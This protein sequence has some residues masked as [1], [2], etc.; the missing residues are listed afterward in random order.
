MSSEVNDTDGN[1]V[2]TSAM[3]F[4]DASANIDLNMNVIGDAIEY[5]LV[6]KNTSDEDYYFDENSLVNNTDY[7]EYTVSYDDNDNVVK[8]GEEK[9]VYLKVT[10]KNK[11]QS[12]NN[13]AVIDDSVVKV[14]LTNGDNSLIIPDTLKDKNILIF[15]VLMI[16]IGA[17]LVVIARNR[18]DMNIFIL[19]ILPVVLLPFTV[20]AVCKCE[21]TVN[22]KV[23][24]DPK[25]A[26]FL[27]GEEINVKIKTLAGIDLTGV[28]NPYTKAATNITAIKKATSEPISANKEEKNIVSTSDSP[29][30]IY[31]WFDNGTLY[32]WSEDDTPA[33][34]KNSQRFFS[35]LT[36]M[37]DISGIETFDASNAE[38]V[39]S[40]LYYVN[41]EDI[42]PLRNWN[43][44]S[45]TQT[46]SFFAGNNALKRTDALA[47][48]DVSNVVNF[49]QM[50]L[51]NTSLE[52]LEGLTNWNTS[53][54]KYMS[55]LFGTNTSLKSIK[56]LENW[57]VSHFESMNG[58]LS[59]CSNLES[60][61]EIENWDVSSAEA[62]YGFFYNL[63]KI[64]SLD[65][66]KWNPVNVT[67]T[68]SM[69]Y[70]CKELEELDLSSW[71][72]TSKLTNME[73]MFRGMTKLK[74][75]NISKFDTRA[76]TNFNNIFNDSTSLEH[77]Y[78]GP[79]WN[80]SANTASTSTAFP[81]SCRLPNFSN[82]N[83]SYRDLRWANTSETGYLT[84]RDN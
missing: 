21:L 74:T 20:N 41:V 35:R 56:G 80:I 76:V 15:V 43:T 77:I 79:N 61:K 40:F 1:I 16:I 46:A 69:F 81:T 31:M 66:S 6:L 39:L 70:N 51:R 37:T 25:E 57:D 7:I 19:L 71:T 32:W 18:K 36:N 45:F 64:T 72:D 14:N 44:S 34:N 58:V 33:L 17:A 30:P 53:S 47:D 75:L 83:G 73:G 52:S 49:N 65:L 84:L 22:S 11:V 68:W 13:N 9:I 63:N 26:M 29:Y 59:E 27:P 5:K 50:F 55:G 62:L 60:A 28:S 4:E 23:F 10:Y 24:I 12:G 82:T 3:T 67:E 2:E 8:S 48:W 38:D 54:G 78:V 42:S